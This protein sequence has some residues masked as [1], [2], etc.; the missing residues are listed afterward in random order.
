MNERSTNHITRKEFKDL[1]IAVDIKSL[2]YRNI[3][4]RNGE[5]RESSH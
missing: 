2:T 1:N 5:E 4:L 3:V